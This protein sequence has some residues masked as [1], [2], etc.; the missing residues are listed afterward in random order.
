MNNDDGGKWRGHVDKQS[1]FF[2]G[3]RQSGSQLI[4]QTQCYQL[5]GMHFQGGGVVLKSLDCA[6][7]WI[8]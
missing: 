3:F 7:L 6:G 4:A 1:F 8:R 5:H 2:G